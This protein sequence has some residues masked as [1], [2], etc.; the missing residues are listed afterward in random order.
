MITLE[1]LRA[2]IR[3]DPMHVL[4]QLALLN[5]IDE[6]FPHDSP[7]LAALSMSAGWLQVDHDQIRRL[8][9]DTGSTQALV[10]V[11]QDLWSGDERSSL[12]E[13]VGRCDARRQYMV[14]RA[15]LCAVQRG[16]G[17]YRGVILDML[18][19]EE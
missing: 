7:L 9:G 16:E 17:K 5:A 1:D 6:Q 4:P 13:I 15:I 11:A 10:S 2:A 19:I 3:R 18:G 8:A 14:V 12:Y